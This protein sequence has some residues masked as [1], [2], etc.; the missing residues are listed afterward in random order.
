MTL[1]SVYGGGRFDTKG[2]KHTKLPIPRLV[3]RRSEHGVTDSYLARISESEEPHRVGTGTLTSPG[4]NSSGY[5]SEP[6]IILFVVGAGIGD[7]FNQLA[8]WRQSEN[9]FYANNCLILIQR[10]SRLLF[11]R[12][13]IERSHNCMIGGVL[14][15]LKVVSKC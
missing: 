8:K 3:R 1:S 2:I 6:S 12:L 5:G 9:W 14:P 4:F 15:L 10:L 7:V 11:G 13:N